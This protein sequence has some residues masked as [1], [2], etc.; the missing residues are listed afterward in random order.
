MLGNATAQI[1][2]LMLMG[3]GDGGGG[4]ISRKKR[5]ILVT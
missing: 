4:Q 2:Q 3:R 1:S 5:Y